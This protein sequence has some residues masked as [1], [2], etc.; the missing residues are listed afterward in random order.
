VAPGSS[1]SIVSAWRCVPLADVVAQLRTTDP[2]RTGIIAIDGR[3]AGG[4]TT[5]AETLHT[6]MPN[7]AVVHTD[8]VAWNH[9]MFD[10]ADALA[11]NVIAPARSGEPI[12][13]QPP[14]WA[15]NGRLGTLDLPGRLD[16]LI[17]EGVGAGRRALADVIDVLIWVQS[18]FD[19]A[20]ERG[21]ARD[22]ASGVNGGPDE[23]RK[24]WDWWMAAE[25]PFLE[26]E[27]PWS[28]ADL[29]VAG[30]GAKTCPGRDQIAIHP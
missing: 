6:A 17:V 18:D 26:Q 29:T 11:D 5:L 25:L 27:E 8:D 4:K 30:S 7:S 23:T 2:G 19:T 24:F 10:W 20:Q 21:L 3:S 22:I 14:G 28:R 12:Q 13:F 15:A 16:T 1:E 9:S